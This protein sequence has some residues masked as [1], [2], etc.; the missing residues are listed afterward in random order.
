MAEEP[1]LNQEQYYHC[2]FRNRTHIVVVVGGAV[3]L[4]V[5]VVGV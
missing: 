3:P 2:A 5:V 1:A 4:A